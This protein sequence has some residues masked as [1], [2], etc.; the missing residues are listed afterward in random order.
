MAEFKDLD[1]FFDS[2][3]A[4]PIGGKR[5]VVPAPDAETGVL[6][7]RLMA[8][9]VVAANGGQVDAA[10]LDDG[11]E[12]DMYQRV[13]G[14]V[15]G[16]LR[17]N[18]VDWLKIKLA[19]VTAFLWITMGVDTAMRYWESGGQAG[20]AAAPDPGAAATTTKRPASGSGTSRPRAT[21]AAAKRSAGK[22]S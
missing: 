15:Y 8:A 10:M 16:Q 11:Q 18:G 14:P 21:K 5:Y 4:L 20:E 6:C 9:G 2:T 7:E 3:L 1:D 12:L 13:L 22:K 19:G 17:A